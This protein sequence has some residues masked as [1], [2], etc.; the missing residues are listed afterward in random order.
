MLAA[1]KITKSFGPIEA[2]SDVSLEVASGTT[3]VVIGPSGCGKTTLVRVI[4]GLVSPDQGQVRFG[5]EVLGE[6]N[7]SGLRRRIGYVVQGGALFPHMTAWSNVAL[8]PK[9]LG[10]SSAEISR[11]L[12]SLMEIMDLS[13]KALNQYPSELSGGQRQRVSLMRALVLDPEVLVLDEPFGALDPIVRFQLQTH[14][15]ALFQSLRKT[16]L[17]VT[18]D[19]AE[20]AFFGDE[21]IL[22]RAG[23]I[24]QRGSISDLLHRPKEEFVE[25]F[26]SAQRTLFDSIQG[27]E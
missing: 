6:K 4:M 1:Q 27:V 13:T 21:I 20:A 17:M 3:G 2:L 22:M 9:H 23:M 25:I 24:V 10:W 7:M 16:V 11:K 14:L 18:H 26:V 12:G 8:M 15:R 19:I 5:S